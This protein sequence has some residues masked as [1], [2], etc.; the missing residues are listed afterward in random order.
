V[1]YT[2]DDVTVTWRQDG[3]LAWLRTGDNDWLAHLAVEQWFEDHQREPAIAWVVSWL[4]PAAA[5]PTMLSA[6]IEIPALTADDPA[7]QR[8][9]VERAVSAMQ[10]PPNIPAP[11]AIPSPTPVDADEWSAHLDLQLASWE[12]AFG[13]LL[14][15]TAPNATSGELGRYRSLAQLLEWTYAIDSSLSML[16]QGLSEQTREQRSLD[17]D[18]QAQSAATQNA[19][20]GTTFDVS[21]DPAFAAFIQ[22]QADR[23]PYKHWSDV[24]LAGAFQREFF[25]AIQ[26]VRGQLIHAATSAPMD[27]RQFRPGAEPRWKW[28]ESASFARGRA[29][30]AGRRAYDAVLA[31]RDVTGLVSHLSDV[32]RNAAVGLETLRRTESSGA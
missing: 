4:D 23:Q 26:W 19:V 10:T 31:E 14:E 22:R 1:K 20:V 25:L 28:R 16:W 15:A 13:E 8:Y 6:A 32:F 11:F 3:L 17:T 30:D 18:A 2:A 12:R 21:T 27:L 5:E 29:N 9:L 24:Y 7:R